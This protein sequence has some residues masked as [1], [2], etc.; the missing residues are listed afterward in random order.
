L[1]YILPDT[2]DHQPGDRVYAEQILRDK[3]HRRIKKDGPLENDF[4]SCWHGVDIAFIFCGHTRPVWYDLFFHQ[5]LYAGF[6]VGIIFSYVEGRIG[7][8]FIGSVMAISFIFAGGFTRSVAKWLML[9]WGV[10]EQW[11]P[12]MTGL[13]FALPLILF[14]CFLEKVPQPDEADVNERTQRVPMNRQTGNGL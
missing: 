10:T 4:F 3:I 11:M 8:D 13:L 12:F 9:K 7:T 2:A 5:R 1:G 14:I 6:Y